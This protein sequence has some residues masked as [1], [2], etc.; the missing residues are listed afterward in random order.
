[1]TATPRPDPVDLVVAVALTLAAQAEIWSPHLVPGTGEIDG[2]RPVLAVTAVLMT[3]PLVFRRTR[4][5]G[6]STTVLGAAC[7]QQ[8]LTTP[9]EGLSPL[10]AMLLAGYSVGAHAA[11]RRAVVGAALLTLTAAT[12]GGSDVVF[13]GLLLLSAWAAGVLVHRQRHQVAHLQSDREVLIAERQVAAEQGAVQE[14]RRIARELHDV[15]AHRVSMMVVQA[16]SADALLATSP[17][18]ARA[19]VRAVEEAGREALG[20]LRSL[21]GLLRADVVEF[22]EPSQLAPPPGLGEIE[23]LV[24]RARDA[25][26]PV[27]YLVQ[28]EVRRVADA[29]GAAA[30]RV[31]QEA[32]TNV[33]KHGGRAATSVD[34]TYGPDHLEVLISDVGKVSGPVVPG[35]GLSGMRERV[36]FVGGTLDVGPGEDGC[37]SVLARL[38]YTEAAP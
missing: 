23:A 29:V 33:V 34:L 31:V 17:D 37:F 28:G 9:T 20:E 18:A 12:V 7:A 4:P 32:I 35:F 8:I 3:V 15:V 30:F 11:G 14:R 16:Q 36:D 10:A 21:L 1:M 27:A 19:S 22:G 38:P 25:G 2:S 6:C 24:A 5:L 13:V 26:L